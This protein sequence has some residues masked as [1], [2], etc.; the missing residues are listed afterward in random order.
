MEKLNRNFADFLRLL[1]ANHVKYLV[2]GGYAVGYHGAVRA[3][4]DMDVFVEIS[5]AN[6]A[7]LVAAFQSFGFNVPGLRVEI[8][9]EEGK[10]VRIGHPP[11]RIEVLNSISGVSFAECFAQRVV[12]VI[13]GVEMSIIDRQNLV[14]NKLASGRLKDLADAEALSPKKTRN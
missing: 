12:E 7:A 8:F 5:P 11:T 1:N 10:I 3:T 13:D 14:K 2:I 9:L 6:A 4:G